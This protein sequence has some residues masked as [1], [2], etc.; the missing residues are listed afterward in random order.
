MRM[1]GAAPRS[2]SRL[3]LIPA[4]AGWRCCFRYPTSPPGS[5]STRS[6]SFRCDPPVYPGNSFQT[7][8]YCSP[9]YLLPLPLMPRLGPLEPQPPG[10]RVFVFRE[11]ILRVVVEAARIGRIPNQ[12]APPDLRRPQA[13]VDQVSG[14]HWS[15]AVRVLKDLRVHHLLRA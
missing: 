5:R 4:L 12:A 15:V 11:V 1:A 3:A 14:I 9:R 10:V 13:G 2:N 7:P 6:G 8:P